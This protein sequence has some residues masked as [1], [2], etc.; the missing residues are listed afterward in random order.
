MLL[1]RTN[2]T[3]SVVPLNCEGTLQCSQH[4]RGHARQRQCLP[5]ARSQAILER[6]VAERNDREW[7]QLTQ[8]QA[9][10]LRMLAAGW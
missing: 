9:W 1:R 5:A 8:V 4:P 6:H 10:P 2:R 7:K 3:L